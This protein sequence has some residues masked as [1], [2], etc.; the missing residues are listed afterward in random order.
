V[1]LTTRSGEVL[2]ERVMS[3][4]GGPTRPLSREELRRKFAGNAGRTL[5]AAAVR[6]L[7]DAILEMKGSRKVSELMALAAS[8]AARPGD[9]P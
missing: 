9:T 6:D 7:G 8:Q 4:R 1:R 3:N 5:K 2:E